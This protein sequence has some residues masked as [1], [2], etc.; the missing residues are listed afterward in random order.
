M[1]KKR[2]ETHLMEDASEI[3]IGKLLPEPWVIRKLH[4]DYGVDYTIEVFEKSG[5]SFPTMGE[6]LYVQAKSIASTEKKVIQLASRMN[7]EKLTSSSDGKAEMEL[8]VIKYQLDCDTIDNARLMGPA[9][10]LL[11]FLVDLALEEVYYICITDYYDKIIE[12][13]GVKLGGQASVLVNIPYGN[14]LTKQGSADVMRFFA[15][16]AKLYGLISLANYQH[17]EVQFLVGNIRAER[18][19]KCIALSLLV[20]RRFALR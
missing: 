13:S 3:I 15:C 16:R 10:P 4:P 12:P 8:D 19:I 7:V 1:A 6:F 14:R 11:L 9:A 20:L 2:G 5:T 17:R 18:D